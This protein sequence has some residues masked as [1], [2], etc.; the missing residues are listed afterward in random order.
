MDIHSNLPWPSCDL[1]NFA[2]HG[3]VVDG[4]RCAS[5][6]GFLQSLKFEDAGQARATRALAGMEAKKA[7]ADRNA[8]WQSA[9][10]L[11]WKGVEM[12]RMGE[13]LA[14]LVDK[15]F[16]ALFAQSEPFRRAL[17]ATHG[18]E[19]RHAIGEGD[20]AKT[21]LTE[22]EFCARLENLRRFGRAR[23]PSGPRGPKPA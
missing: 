15:A 19:L 17:A 6:E 13:P 18:E 10:A 22:E 23:A 14:R 3:F 4:E 8:A 16:E 12:E 7:G 1:S 11:W 21:V 5:M 20:P 2:A 9:K